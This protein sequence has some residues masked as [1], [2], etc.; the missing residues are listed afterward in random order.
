LLVTA[1]SRAEHL[2][3]FRIRVV[4]TI[5]DDK[6][7]RRSG[8]QILVHISKVVIDIGVLEREGG[9]ERERGKEGEGKG[10]REDQ[11]QFLAICS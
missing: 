7:D 1:S 8:V 5:L 10:G 3:V 2:L 4:E 6:V 9:R 11:A